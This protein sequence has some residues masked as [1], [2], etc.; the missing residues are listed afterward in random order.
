MNH[1]AH[2]GAHPPAT[3]PRPLPK[4]SLVVISYNADRVL[5]AFLSSLAHLDYPSWECIVVDNAS[6]DA[7]L[8]RLEQSTAAT[9]IPLRENIGFGRACNL[10]AQQADGGVL[11]FLN[12]DM[13]MPP[14]WLRRTV[15]TLLGDERIAAVAPMTVQPGE[16][17]TTV[18]EIEDVTAIPGCATV[19]RAT[20]FHSLGGFDPRIFL[21][22]E[23]TDL[24]WRAR[25]RGRRIVKDHGAYVVHE[26]GGTGGGDAMSAE[27]IKNGLY[28]H[29]KLATWGK[30]AAFTVRMGAKTAI[31]FAQLRDPAILGAWLAN[32]QML[33]ATLRSRRAELSGVPRQRQR[34]VERDLGRQTRS[35][36]SA[37]AATRRKTRF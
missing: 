24:C 12:P 34:A 19:I 1:D 18:D 32:L 8:Q 28:V 26:R 20:D 35:R 16:Q 13:V 4:A 21:Y 2:P 5:P 23:D 37:W 29:F 14:F 30:T 15:L 31:R 17:P 9:V 7:S 22:W 6:T 33:P 25:L 27:Q 3:A 36:R 10:A 11:V